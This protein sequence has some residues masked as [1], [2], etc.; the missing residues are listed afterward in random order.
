MS[1]C[2]RPVR[3]RR[4]PPSSTSR[5]PYST[6]A[7]AHPSPSIGLPFGHS[8][9][10]CKYSFDAMSA[11]CRERCH[12][13]HAQRQCRAAGY[14]VAT[15]APRRARPRAAVGR[16]PGRPPRAPLA[17]GRRM[18]ARSAS[19]RV[20]QERTRQERY[21]EVA[22]RASISAASAATPGVQPASVYAPIVSSRAAETLPMRRLPP[23]KAKPA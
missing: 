13:A 11:P 20:R 3:P 8:S 16:R 10:T 6:T 2:V 4:P 22:R 9:P 21:A 18:S 17:A 14:T 1:G 23:C 5:F 12:C 7:G 15:Q 19:G